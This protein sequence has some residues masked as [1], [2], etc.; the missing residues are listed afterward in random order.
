MQV[1]HF[2]NRAF[3]ITICESNRMER[4]YDGPI[5]KLPN[6]YLERRVVYHYINK[7]IN[8]VYVEV[9]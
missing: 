1:K 4:L 6:I 7:A 5:D 2:L 8:N 9:E 3:N